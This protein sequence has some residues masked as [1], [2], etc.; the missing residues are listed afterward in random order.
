MSLPIRA[1]ILAMNP[2]VPGKP[3]EEVKR[4]LGLTRVIKLASNENPLGPSPKAVAAIRAAADQLHFYPDGASFELKAAIS[5][6]FGLPA[7]NIMLGNGSDEIIHLLSLILLQKGDNL[8][9]GTPGFARYPA[10]AHLVE[11]AVIG[12]PMDKDLRH[13]LTAIA[14][15]ATERTKLIFIANPNNPT[16]TIVRRGE[17]DGFLRD[18][19]PQ[20]V[21][22]LDEAYA[23]FTVGVDDFPNSIPY[24]K[25]GQNV[26]GLRTLSKSHGLAGI[27]IGFG[28]A[29]AALVDAYHRA[30]EPFN[31]NLLAQVAGIAALDDED[32][33][34]ATVAN[35][36]EGLDRLNA[37]FR[38]VGCHPFESY[39]NFVL[40]DLGRPARPIYDALLRRGVIVRP[41]DLLGTPNAIRVTV[42]TP[43]EVGT[44]IEEFH[45]VMALVG[46]S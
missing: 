7:E 22:V 35:N 29:D 32:H 16:G 2:Y 43:E 8:I 24:V 31:V 9:M 46:A 11:A 23:D 34:A 21:V 13:D 40:A 14:K 3:V 19:P 33:V 38:A 15:A 17:V 20:A 37:A 39:A 26:V 28:F 1:N 44:F 5:R 45:A 30:R 4:E 6:K 27:R 12:V 10:G 25:A 36:Q 41:G 42:G 18:L